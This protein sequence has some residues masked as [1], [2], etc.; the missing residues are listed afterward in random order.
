MEELKLQVQ[1]LTKAIPTC[2]TGRLDERGIGCTDFYTRRIEEQLKNVLTKM[3]EQQSAWLVEFEKN[4]HGSNN[5]FESNEDLVTFDFEDEDVDDYCPNG[6]VGEAA[7]IQFEHSKKRHELS[8]NAMK[9]RKVTVGMVKGNLTVLPSDF[10]FPTMTSEQLVRNWLLGNT[11][12]CIVPYRTLKTGDL[13]HVNGVRQRQK[14]ARF[15][16]VIEHYARKENCWINRGEKWNHSK[17]TK[18]W[19]AIGHRYIFKYGNAN[20]SRLESASW[21]TML[22]KMVKH[23]AFK[24]ERN[25][26]K[27][28][29]EWELSIYNNNDS[30]IELML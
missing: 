27:D 25:R 19:A 9:R 29:S 1:Q 16:A 5:E 8:Q 6:L 2:I 21:T 24:K 26:C 11:A 13:R 23:G 10:Q 30:K 22:N 15:M 20:D 28:N 3:D 4:L 7:S 14:M 17:V 12:S 18:M